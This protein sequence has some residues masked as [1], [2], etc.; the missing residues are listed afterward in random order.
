MKRIFL[1]SLCLTACATSPIDRE[2]RS[3]RDKVDAEYEKAFVVEDAP[4]VFNEMNSKEFRERF[5]ASVCARD[6]LDDQACA[7][8]MESAYE[9]RMGL[10]YFAADG[11]AV[12]K[13]CDAYPVE[14]KQ[15]LPFEQWARESHNKRLTEWRDGHYK[16][17]D[18]WREQAQA[19]K[20]A[21]SRPDWG[22]I[23]AALTQMSQ[24]LSP[25]STQT[26]CQTMPNGVGG[27][28]TTCR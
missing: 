24:T 23:G 7:R 15:G 3:Y 16:Y 22:R 21:A 8:Q 10:T 14:C 9:A 6:K 13:K 26:N 19:Q 25:K 5:V 17:I 28:S 4:F 1:A 27:F 2:H 12:F 18:S 20:D 11:P